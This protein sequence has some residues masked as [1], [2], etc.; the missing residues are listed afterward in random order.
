MHHG[1][2]QWTTGTSHAKSAGWRMDRTK[3]EAM[4]QQSDSLSQSVS[5]DDHQEPDSVL[6]GFADPGNTASL[7]FG[8]PC[9]A[10]YDYAGC[11]SCREFRTDSPH[12][13]AVKRA[14]RRMRD[15]LGETQ[16]LSDHAQAALLSP[17]HFHRV[18]TSVTAA[19]PARFLAAL[20]IVEAEHL[21]IGSS[22]T[23]TDIAAQV[24]Y[25]SLGTF[26]TQFTRL[27][28]E[29]P[30]RF[31]VLVDRIGDR[32]IGEAVAPMVGR[33][34][35]SVSRPSLQ[36]CITGGPQSG[37]L[38]FAGLFPFGI[39]QTKPVDCIVTTAPAV[40]GFS[41]VPDGEYHVLAVVF[42][43]TVTIRDAILEDS[44]SVGSS[45]HPIQV[46]GGRA[47]R[48]ISLRL[49]QPSLVDPPVVLAVPHLASQMKG[50]KS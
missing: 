2:M 24:G 29:S 23:V 50:V 37:G 34:M 12:I 7:E 46:N 20:R 32:Q 6:E 33:K 15:R 41:G 13:E 47:Q 48:T 5:I 4:T 38:V 44:P 45:L 26:T 1:D 16:S 9:P 49:R 40:V 11:M 28:G 31:R 17:F 3:V 22:L 36:V 21:L 14:V 19:T 42:D 10:C 39:P 25:A 8:Y 18:F 35:V 27:V 30:R 43:P